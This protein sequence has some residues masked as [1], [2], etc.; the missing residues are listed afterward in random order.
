MAA[1][2]EVDSHAENFSAVAWYDSVSLSQVGVISDTNTAL[3]PAPGLDPQTGCESELQHPTFDR[4]FPMPRLPYLNT[5]LAVKESPGVESSEAP[6]APATP[7]QT[8]ESF[9]APSR[10]DRTLRRV[11]PLLIPVDDALVDTMTRRLELDEHSTLFDPAPW[12]LS[13]DARPRGQFSRR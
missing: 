7:S 4:H 5:E 12:G 10:V 8:A 2:S 6:T 1:A 13:L 3:Y 11:E 9:A